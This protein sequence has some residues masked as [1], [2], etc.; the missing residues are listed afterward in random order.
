MGYY[1][2]NEKIKVYRSQNYFYISNAEAA[3]CYRKSKHL[4]KIPRNKCTKEVTAINDAIF[5]F[6]NLKILQH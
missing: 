1:F 4:I 2:D 5:Q 3:A 6:I